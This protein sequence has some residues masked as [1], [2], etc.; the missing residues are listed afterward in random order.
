ML[1]REVICITDI[2]NYGA[3]KK[4]REKKRQADVQCIKVDDFQRRA[5]CGTNS[6]SQNK[7]L[8]EI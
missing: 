8:D 5:R 4:Q 6:S 1:K 3:R 7:L 2:L